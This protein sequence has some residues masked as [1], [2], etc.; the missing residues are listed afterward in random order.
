ML[1]SARRL[2]RVACLVALVA[3]E[4]LAAQHV[5]LPAPPRGP[6]GED[7]IETQNGTRCRQSMNAN[8]AYLDVGAV[9]STGNYRD[10]YVGPWNH[11]VDGREDQ[12]TGYV[13]MTLPLGRQPRRLDCSRLYEMELQRLRREIELLQMATE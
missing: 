12:V 3:A 2:S 10:P 1:A 5:Y 4:P 6:G 7:V 11:R 8:G 13:R 9:G